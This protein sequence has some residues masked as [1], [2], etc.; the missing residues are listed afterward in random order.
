MEIV[1]QAISNVPL[2]TRAGNTQTELDKPL[3]KDIIHGNHA[4]DSLRDKEGSGVLDPRVKLM[5]YDIKLIR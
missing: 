4:R 1:N 5:Y 2:R 3:A